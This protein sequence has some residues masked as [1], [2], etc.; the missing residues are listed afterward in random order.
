M[1]FGENRATP[2]SLLRDDS[3]KNAQICIE[4]IMNETLRGNGLRA[5][6]EILRDD[7]GRVNECACE[8]W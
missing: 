4:M 3:A 2:C 8:F 7:V 5:T 6:A 1:N